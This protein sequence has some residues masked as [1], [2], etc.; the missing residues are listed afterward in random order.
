MR[1]ES[2]FALVMTVALMGLAI[3]SLPYPGSLIPVAA[4]AIGFAIAV[5]PRRRAARTRAELERSWSITAGHLSDAMV[6]LS[7]IDLGDD[8]RRCLD[9]ARDFLDHNE[10]ELAMDFIAEAA[11]DH[12]VPDAVWVALEAAA[13]N[14]QLL[15][16]ATTFGRNA[17]DRSP[18][19][20]TTG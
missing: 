7:G 1:Y 8:G 6:V 18:S 5:W 20:N 4:V 12:P 15:D 3:V 11:A 13:A 19:R 16:R 17:Q 9:E 10:L 2:T 14:M